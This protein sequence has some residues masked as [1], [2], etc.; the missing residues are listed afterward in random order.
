MGSQ[1][2]EQTEKV[3]NKLMSKHSLETLDVDK[4][5]YENDDVINAN[6]VELATVLNILQSLLFFDK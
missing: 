4:V 5:Y 3:L 6:L 2:R 1:E